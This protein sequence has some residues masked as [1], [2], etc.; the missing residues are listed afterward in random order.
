[1]K[2]L[3]LISLL[4]TSLVHADDSLSTK[5]HDQYT[6]L[7]AMGMGNAFTA[8]ADDYSLMFYNPAGFAK[9]RYNEVQF[10][11]AGAGVSPKTLTFIDDMKKAS[12]TGTDSQKAAAVSAVLEQ[13]YGK[14]LGGKVQAAEIFWTRKNW[15][16]ALIPVDLT[17]D[18]SFNRQLGPAI[19][20]NVIADTTIAYG[21]GTEI[22]KYVSAGITAKYTHR[23]AVDQ[24]VSALELATDPNILST[25]RFKEGTS[26]DFNLGFMWTPNWFNKAVAKTAV[27]APPEEINIDIKPKEKKEEIKTDANAEQKKEDAKTDELKKSDDEKRS[28]QSEEKPVELDPLLAPD[29]TT[30]TPLVVDEKKP[31]P[32]ADKK[33]ETKSTKKPKA[34]KTETE[35]AVETKSIPEVNPEPNERF[36][37]TFGL[38]INNVLGGNFSKS[39]LINKDANDIPV[40]MYRTID[41]GSHYEVAKFG[42]L[43][44]R[45]MI[46]FKNLLHPDINFNKSFHAGVEF[47]YYPNSWF[48]TQFRAGINQMY[49]TGGATFLFG[50][51]HIDAVTYGEEVGTAS[52][53]IEN[54]V[55][56]AKLG[57]NF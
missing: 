22:N 18:M 27:V 20:L 10:T 43:T 23:D 11:L 16:V 50:I 34:A 7:R 53:K 31:A 37:L 6:S 5:I 26:A 24:S 57:F 47:D 17:I 38:V 28:V 55:Y 40:S 13:Y 19:D 54:R 56:A 36:P 35:P 14:S 39:K 29:L 46:D 41:L 21:Y 45:S 42:D 49:F 3:V 8:V 4:F 25:K 32:L 1:M 44:F 48:K 51:I 30:P 2:T 9:K 52:S 15:G 12:E 33:P